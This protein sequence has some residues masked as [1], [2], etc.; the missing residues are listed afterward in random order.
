[1]RV[2][3][4]IVEDLRYC[5][6]NDIHNDVANLKRPLKYLRLDINGSIFDLDIK[7]I[8]DNEVVLKPTVKVDLNINK[9]RYGEDLISFDEL[10]RRKFR[11]E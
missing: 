7:Y 2:N 10:L 4:I 9:I 8:I 1:M 3:D 5:D 11:N 6:R